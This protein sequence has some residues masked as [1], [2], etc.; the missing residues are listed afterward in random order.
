MYPDQQTPSGE[1]YPVNYL[2]QIAPEQPKKGLPKP[3]LKLAT[4][5]LGGILIITLLAMLISTLTARPDIDRTISARLSQTTSIVDESHKKIKS[6]HLRSL[7]GSLKIMLTNANRDMAIFIKA[8][9]DSSS[10]SSATSAEQ[11]EANR[12]K[13]TLENARLNAEF[14]RVYAPLM[15]YRLETIKTHLQTA[16]ENS[17]NTE[18]KEFLET[19]IN[20]LDPIYEQLAQFN[21]DGS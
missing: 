21:E 1:Q 17:S 14:D 3:N 5:I 6:G 11:E 12:D 20:N 19:T 4:L 7:N 8:K 18:Y 9:E 2:N 15:A 10:K 13:E 16:H